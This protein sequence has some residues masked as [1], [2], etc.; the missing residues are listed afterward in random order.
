MRSPKR[1]SLSIDSKRWANAIAFDVLESCT[2][3]FDQQVYVNQVSYK[4]SACESDW[5]LCS[6]SN[7]VWKCLIWS[8]LNHWSKANWVQG[9]VLVE[10]GSSLWGVRVSDR[11]SSGRPLEA[12]GAVVL[13]DDWAHENRT[14]ST[15]VAVE[16]KRSLKII[17][18]LYVSC[19]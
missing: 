18:W 7:W 4:V 16:L 6:K 1:G 2:L 15:V 5:C 3:T 17:Y 8:F 13:Y 14:R 12:V 11:S 10:Q 19:L 9:L